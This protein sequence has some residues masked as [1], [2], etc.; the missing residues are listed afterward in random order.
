MYT[1][2]PALCSS[3]DLSPQVPGTVR[4]LKLVGTMSWY[5]R[6]PVLC[7]EVPYTVNL[8]QPTG[9]PTIS[10]LTSVSDPHWLYAD[11]DIQLF[12]RMRIRI[13]LWKWMRIHADSDPGSTVK[14]KIFKKT[15]Y[16]LTFNENKVTF[17]HFIP[18]HCFLSF[19]CLIICLLVAFSLPL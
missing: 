8:W 19:L 6:V 12:K 11:P 3:A 1:F 14:N 18:L 4:I 13:Q 9:F 7:N 16:K 17:T 5:D 15:N 2:G 10:H